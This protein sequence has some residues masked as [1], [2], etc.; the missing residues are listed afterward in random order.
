[1]AA[2][3]NDRAPERPERFWNLLDLP[4]REV[5]EKAGHRHVHPAGTVLL[6]EG[7]E[8]ESVLVLL[9][10][11]VKVVAVGVRG[12]QSLLAIRLPGDVL[13]E[14][15][16]VDERRRSASVVALEPIEVLR[17]PLAG[18]V[19]ILRSQPG[20]AYALLRVV[21]TK[22]RIANLRRVQTGET[23]VAERVAVTLAELAADHGRLQSSEI[24]ITLPISQD[25][26]A[27][28][29]GGSR[30]A[31]V[32]ALRVLRE[33]G[34]VRTERQQVT[35]LRPDLLGLRIPSAR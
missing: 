7:S 5:L 20:I 8:A 35:L 9:A 4:Q 22:L 3:L 21:S 18:F 11:R 10:G 33:E 28:M 13:G 29:V 25:E 34:V 2:A 19:D 30:E 16:A 14:L 24:T 27:H 23:T 17:I 12:H 31:V 32:R 15:A 26:L 6:S 1:M